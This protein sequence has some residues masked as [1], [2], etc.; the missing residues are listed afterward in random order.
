MNETTKLFWQLIE[1]KMGPIPSYVK[2]IL[3]LMGYES[4][5]SIRTIGPK[6]ID[7]FQKYVK[8]TDMRKR[9]PADAKMEDF[10]GVLW[11][12]P[13]NANI[14]PGHI[15]LIEQIV[16]FVNLTIVTKGYEHFIVKTKINQ[17]GSA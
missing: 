16:E 15:K 6:D 2:N 14:L 10:F 12:N 11:E 8:S 17:P 13:E 5:I 4:A 1:S 3:R 9:V 7:A